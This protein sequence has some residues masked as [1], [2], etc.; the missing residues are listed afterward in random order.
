MMHGV[1]SAKPRC[2][3]FHKGRHFG[4]IGIGN[5]EAIPEPPQGAQPQPDARQADPY[6]PTPALTSATGK[7]AHDPERHEVAGSMIECLSW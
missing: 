2:G 1:E 4:G 7:R 6:S 3:F 5:G